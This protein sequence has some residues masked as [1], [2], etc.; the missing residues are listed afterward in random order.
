MDASKLK[1][2]LE[3]L[4]PLHSVA[5]IAAMAQDE[6]KLREFFGDSGA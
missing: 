6:R 2:I 5:G 1:Y 3:M 4:I